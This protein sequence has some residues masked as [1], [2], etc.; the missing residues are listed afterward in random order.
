MGLLFRQSFTP[1]GHVTLRPGYNSRGYYQYHISTYLHHSFE[2]LLK[3]SENMPDWVP[4]SSDDLTFQAYLAGLIAA[5]GCIR[6]YNANSRAHALL[7]I[8]LKKPKLLRELS[9]IIGGRLYEVTRAWRLVIYG[10][11]AVALLRHVDIR[12][13]EKVEKARLVMDH[14]GERWSNVEPLWL[15]TVNRIKVQVSQ[16]KA[17]ARLEYIRK[18][19]TPHRA[20]ARLSEA[21]LCQ[22]T[23][24]V[25]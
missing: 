25:V 3:K 18:H 15:E 1:F 4:Q 11:A 23:R 21:T 13:E 14:A 22:E 12:H 17:Q 24:P 8:T 6:L 2:L 9:M 19:G 20:E 16:Y 7:H 5:E 10:K